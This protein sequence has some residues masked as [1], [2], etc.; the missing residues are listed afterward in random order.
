MGVNCKDMVIGHYDVAEEALD[1]II[2]LA[3]EGVVDVIILDSIHSMA[4][5]GAVEDKKGEKSLTTNTM[6]A[7]A[8]KLSEFFARASTRIFKSN[9]AL[10][11]VGQTRKNLGGFIVLDKLSGG[12]AL[13]HNSVLTLH[14]RRGQK[15]NAPC[16][17]CKI[18]FL[19]PDGKFHLQKEKTQD[20]F[21]TVIKI[22]K[23]K[24][25]GGQNEGATVSLPYY[26]DTGFISPLKE[27]EEIPIKIDPKAN[28]EEVK[29]IK[30]NLVKKGYTQFAEET[31]LK[32]IE[33][34][35][36]S[37]IMNGEPDKPI[38]SE[39]AD[40]V[41][42]ELIA[43]GKAGIDVKDSL[44]KVKDIKKK[45]GPLH[46]DTIIIDDVMPEEKPKKRG[47][48]RPKKIDKKEKK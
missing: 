22:D 38:K 20:G 48:G 35:S 25:S 36:V 43:M 17:E 12:N 29:I 8:K 46:A 19:D 32:D 21:E 31:V 1:T 26:Y 5:K 41:E 10:I 27:D 44:E 18:A 33:F 47:R 42:E 30:E 2:K 15:S 23:K 7:L 45:S 13:I 11:M 9:I 14:Q 16:L 39:V 34:D 37:M 28:D 24:C 40:M 3:I 4:P 6:G